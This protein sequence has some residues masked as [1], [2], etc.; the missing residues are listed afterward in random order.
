MQKEA[1]GGTETGVRPR[2]RLL[3]YREG[4]LR[5]FALNGERW[6][7]G[8]A[9]DCDITLDDPT[10]S[11]HH[12]VLER[13]EDQIRFRD[14]EATNPTLLDG[15]R[16]REGL[17]PEGSTILAGETRM[18]LKRV[19]SAARVRVVSEDDRSGEEEAVI[20]DRPFRED[21]ISEV[22]GATSVLERLFWPLAETGSAEELAS[23]L[24]E[25]ALDQTR[26]ERGLLG[27]F[28]PTGHLTVLASCDRRQEGVDFLVPEAVV[29]EA[30]SVPQ[31]FIHA[32]GQGSTLQE[33]V[34]VPLGSE[35]WG[36][37]MLE[38]RLP[39]GPSNR[40]CLRLGKALGEIIRCRLSEAKS[41]EQLREEIQ[42]LRFHRNPAHATIL[43][44]A[45]LHPLLRALKEAGGHD[46]PVLL[47]GEDGTEKEDLARYL[48]A[49]SGRNLGHFVPFLAA[50]LPTHRVEVELYGSV[51][52]GLG[53]PQSGGALLRARGGTLYIENPDALPPPVQT[54]LLHDL[55]VSGVR[56][57]ASVFEH[58]IGASG[59]MLEGLTEIL[60]KIQV[61]IPPLR[62]HAEDIGS[63]AEFIL[64]EM[65]PGP[66]GRPR[67][68]TEGARRKLLEYRW[69]GNLRQLRMV[70][71]AAA[72]R[73]GQ[74]PIAERHLSEDVRTPGAEPA[75]VGLASL[76]EME[77]QHVQRVLEATGGSRS[78]AEKVLGIANSTLYEK[79]KRFDLRG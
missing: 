9:E 77:K 70:L 4:G 69:P 17:F 74:Q 6:T 16:V 61:R 71:E 73:S 29:T 28:D 26:R 37:L 21:P 38:A 67:I 18:T 24:L 35:P 39:D 2:L 12:L 52:P 25:F 33:G 20:I 72:A 11:P 22:A 1:A 51:K 14:L 27:L 40:A 8:R 47:V 76:R 7:V 58:P 43:A 45:R 78:K 64:S 65:G 62:G 57:V 19:T 66:D 23:R 36:L 53:D 30:F 46:R 56:I 49:L 5:R 34:V 13:E 59:G 55:E 31:P 60:S 44:S 48:H 75:D 3:V 63:L 42:R 50:V 54:R 10:V 79:M 41:R 68:L 15:R 32:S